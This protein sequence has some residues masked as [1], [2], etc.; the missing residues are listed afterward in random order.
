MNIDN[1]NSVND[2]TMDTKEMQDIMN[3]EPMDHVHGG[4][5]KRQSKRKSMKS[6]K[7]VMKSKRKS[8][9]AAKKVMKSKRKSMKAS[10]K[11]MKKTIKSKRKMS[12]NALTKFMKK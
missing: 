3:I 10:K 4:S 5:K 12:I 9:K 7:K 1:V 11:V 2:L 6:A 8:M